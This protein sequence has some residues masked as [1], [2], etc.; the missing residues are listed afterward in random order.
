MSE[1]VNIG[2]DSILFDRDKVLNQID[3][4][5]NNVNKYY[6]KNGYDFKISKEEVKQKLDELREVVK[7]LDLKKVVE[8]LPRLKDG[9]LRRASTPLYTSGLISYERTE[10]YY[11]ESNIE[12]LVFCI[13]SDTRIFK[14]GL[15]T[16]RVY[17]KAD[18]YIYDG[19]YN[20]IEFKTK[21]YLKYNDL[22]PG[23]IYLDGKDKEYLFVGVY[24][25]SSDNRKEISTHTNAFIKLDKNT[26]EDLKNSSNFIEF[27]KRFGFPLYRCSETMSLKM[28][29]FVD[30]LFDVNDMLGDVHYGSDH[31]KIITTPV[32]KKWTVDA[33]FFINGNW[34]HK[35]ETTTTDNEEVKKKIA[36]LKTRGTVLSPN[37]TWGCGLKDYIVVDKFEELVPINQ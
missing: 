18:Q 2:K 31:F 14:V 16:D 11:K 25:W 24:E 23:C 17:N 35:E 10:Y 12:L 33:N 36:E 20:K 30:K 32:T 37:E 9:D 13:D 21:T 15:S 28:T 29:T 1:V 26:K 5:E 19:N 6:G 27:C 8:C 22:I 7:I 34:D 3:K 4:Y